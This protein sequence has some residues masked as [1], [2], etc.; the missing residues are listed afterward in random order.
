MNYWTTVKKYC[1]ILTLLYCFAYKMWKQSP[2]FTILNLF[3]TICQVY[4]FTVLQISTWVSF[5]YMKSIHFIVLFRNIYR[6]DD[7]NENIFFILGF[8]F[9]MLLNVRNFIVVMHDIIWLARYVEEV[10]F[11]NIVGYQKCDF[12][13]T[14]SGGN[15]LL[16][17]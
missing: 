9:K 12:L 5:I 14:L 7:S 13:N 2:L 3:N 1:I 10:G 4:F 17:Q 15:G 16:A 6:I 8:S 11:L